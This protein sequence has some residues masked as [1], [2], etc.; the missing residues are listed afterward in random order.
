[1]KN[2]D[3][4]NIL[5]NLLGY[6][7]VDEYTENDYIFFGT[8]NKVSNYPNSDTLTRSRKTNKYYVWS[9]SLEDGEDCVTLKFGGIEIKVVNLTD[10]KNPVMTVKTVKGTRQI[11]GH[12]LPYQE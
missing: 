6:Y 9:M 5:I 11:Q 2:I 8:N 7:W 10:G 12:V 4:S 3:K 1:M